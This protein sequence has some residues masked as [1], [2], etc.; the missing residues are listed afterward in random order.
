MAYQPF[1]QAM[2]LRLPISGIA[3]GINLERG[4]LSCGRQEQLSEI[5]A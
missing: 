5:T 3:M 4:P 2:K 1:D